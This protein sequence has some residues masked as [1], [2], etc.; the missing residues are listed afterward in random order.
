MTV[1]DGTRFT[2]TNDN[3]VFMHKDFSHDA[4]VEVATVEKLAEIQAKYDM[5]VEEYEELRRRV[6]EDR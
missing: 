2:I 4:P 5:L 3:R 6:D 1:S